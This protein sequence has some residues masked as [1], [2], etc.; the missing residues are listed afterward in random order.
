MVVIKVELWPRGNSKEAE[1][2]GMATIIND[3]S[4]PRDTRG[5]Y[6]YS[7]SKRGGKGIL[8][9]GMVKGFPRKDL[10]AWDLLYR[11]LRNA[12]GSRNE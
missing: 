9:Q 2:I 12:F 1:L 3:G 4:S 8:R 5:N 7:F 11:A 10:G 6:N